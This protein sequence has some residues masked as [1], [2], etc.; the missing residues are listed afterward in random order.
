MALCEVC[1]NEYDK[2]MQIT[3]AGASHTFDCFECAIHGLAPRCEHCECAV[4]GHGHEADGHFFCCAHCA[5]QKGV[6]RL[7]DRADA[8]RPPA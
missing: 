7:V 6:D 8:T 1:G 2:P 5:A 3:V 4:I